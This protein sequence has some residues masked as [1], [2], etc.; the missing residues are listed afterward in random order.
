MNNHHD[1]NV[2]MIIIIYFLSCG[3]L[4][5]ISFVTIMNFVLSIQLGI[6]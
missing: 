3:H 1:Q 6:T 2:I 4:Y 5:M